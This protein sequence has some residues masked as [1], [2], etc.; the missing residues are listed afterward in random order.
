MSLHHIPT[1]LAELITSDGYL[2]KV[3]IVI[4]LGEINSLP[5]T[6]SCGF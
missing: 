3:E 1:K 5:R 4:V 6:C 2:F